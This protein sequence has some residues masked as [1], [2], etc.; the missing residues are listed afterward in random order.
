VLPDSSGVRISRR[1]DERVSERTEGRGE[2]GDPHRQKI[3]IRAP[4][5]Y[6]FGADVKVY[7]HA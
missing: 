1:V 3:L 5:H 4:A 6:A 2:D 7:P